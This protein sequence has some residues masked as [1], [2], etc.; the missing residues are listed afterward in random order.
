M[1]DALYYL[2]KLI[3][4]LYKTA[5]VQAAI[6]TDCIE[7]VYSNTLLLKTSYLLSTDL[8]RNYTD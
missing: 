6:A 4:Y 8:M 3:V 7:T 5:L 1:I 2:Q